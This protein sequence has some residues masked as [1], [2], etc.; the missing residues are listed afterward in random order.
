MVGQVPLVSA[1]PGKAGK[2]GRPAGVTAGLGS[3]MAADGTDY[4]QAA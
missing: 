4:A 2:A 1:G 3:G